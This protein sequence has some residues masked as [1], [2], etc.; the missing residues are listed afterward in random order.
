MTLLN[1]NER[2]KDREMNNIQLLKKFST[3]IRNLENKQAGLESSEAP[4]LKIELRAKLNQPKKPSR[5][6]TKKGTLKK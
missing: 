6:L 3:K 5:G 2:L 4:S 1:A